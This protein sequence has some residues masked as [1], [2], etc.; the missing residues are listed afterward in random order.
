M[1]DSENNER[2]L[3]ITR[4]FPPLVGGMEKLN[5]KLAEQLAKRYQTS[6]ITIKGADRFQNPNQNILTCPSNIT[7]FLLCATVKIALLAIKLKHSKEDNKTI[8]LSGSGV[9]A[10]VAWLGSLLTGYKWGVYVHG[11]D[12][13]AANS[14]YQKLFLPIIR[15]ADFCIANSTATKKCATSAGIPEEK[16]SVIH[17]GVDSPQRSISDKDTEAWKLRRGIAASQILISVGRLTKR[18]GLN[19]FIRECLPTI[20]KYKPNTVLVIV[21]PEPTDALL[22]NSVGR[23]ALVR[24]ATKAGVQDHVT[25]L[26]KV[27]D[28]ELMTLYSCA[29][30]HIFPLIK[31]EG[32]MEGFGMVAAEAASYGVPTVAFSEGGVA[33]AV[34][35]STTGYLVPSGQ[36]ELFTTKV[37]TILNGN[38]DLSHKKIKRYATRFEWSVFGAKIDKIISGYFK[39][40]E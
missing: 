30:V 13:I 25:F 18:K 1:I 11:L 26:G 28:Q 23:T 33:D 20:T 22:A 37:L 40:N 24:T 35:D 32:D 34:E 9:S 12:I 39:R 4:N 17:P 2:V 6:I 29:D 16:I 19:E 31:V 15:K 27:S 36:Y 14:V 8:I 5:F 21:G 10:P 38:S 7:L 3:L